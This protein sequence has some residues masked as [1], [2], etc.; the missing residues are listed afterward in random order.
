MK[1]CSLCVIL[2]RDTLKKRD[3]IKAAKEVL[4]G[5]ADI[6]QYRDKLSRDMEFIEKARALKKIV[7][8]TGRIFIV[9]DRVDVAAAVGADGVHLGQEDMPIRYARKIMGNK[10]IGVSS[11]SRLEAHRAVK[12][13]ADYIGIGPIFRTPGKPGAKPIGL[14]SLKSITSKICIP[15]FA[16]GGVNLKNIAVLKENGIKNIAVISAAIKD[17]NVYNSVSRLKR[18]LKSTHRA[19]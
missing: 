16:I 17:K 11:H 19:K 9:N 7:K 5:G 4:R 2:D 14:G 3:L 18:E 15:V 13:G 1:N 12:D 10:I 6:I 8:S